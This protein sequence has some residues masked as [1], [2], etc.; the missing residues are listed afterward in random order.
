VGLSSVQDS[1]RALREKLARGT[2]VVEL[3]PEK[4]IVRRNRHADM[5]TLLQDTAARGTIAL[6]PIYFT[7]HGTHILDL[8]GVLHL[9]VPAEEQDPR[10]QLAHL[11]EHVARQ[12]KVLS[13]P[14]RVAILAD[15][16][17]RPA[18]ITE[19]A[20]RFSLSQPTVSMHVKLLRQ[21]E[22]LIPRKQGT[23]TSYSVD[24]ERVASLFEDVEATLLPHD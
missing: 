17:R 21:A 13:D 23:R 5:L 11:A 24:R 15:L 6:S 10:Q 22:L 16:A 4:H 18:S 12:V 9:G 2:S 19:L 7:G 14:S 20:E 8:P 1:A 3:L